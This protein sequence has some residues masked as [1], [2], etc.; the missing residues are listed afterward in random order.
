MEKSKINLTLQHKILNNKHMKKIII[1]PI[2]TAIILLASCKNEKNE[3]LAPTKDTTI[4][5][6]YQEYSDE[7]DM[8]TLLTENNDIDDIDTQNEIDTIEFQNKEEKTNNQKE[9]NNIMTEDKNGNIKPATETDINQ[10]NKNFYIVIGSYKNINN[11]KKRTDKLI[12]KGYSAEILPKF[13]NLNRV[14]IAKFNN[15]KSAREEM[16]N[17]RKKF[18]DNSFWLLCR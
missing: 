13:G 2:L 17:L 3:A 11:A 1:L 6:E 8:D 4:Y 5:P 16:K 10:N 9:N 18:C 7:S 15:K 12:K 14:S